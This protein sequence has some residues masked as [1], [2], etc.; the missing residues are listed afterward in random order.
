MLCRPKHTHT[1]IQVHY[2]KMYSIHLVFKPKSSMLPKKTKIYKIQTTTTKLCFV[3][4]KQKN[5]R[6][7]MFIMCSLVI[8]TSCFNVTQL[9]CMQNI[10]TWKCLCERERMSV[11]MFYDT[12]SMSTI[13]RMCL[14]KYG[15]YGRYKPT[16]WYNFVMFFLFL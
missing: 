9:N 12:K 2:E 16:S 3:V 4:T 15:Y 6:Q 11:L 14:T 10:C 1:S 5:T 7:S 13:M 8:V